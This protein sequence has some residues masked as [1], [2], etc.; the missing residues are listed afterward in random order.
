MFRFKNNEFLAPAFLGG[1]GLL[2]TLH[3]MLT[4]ILKEKVISYSF[5][6]QLIKYFLVLLVFRKLDNS[7]VLWI[8]LFYFTSM[9]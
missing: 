7:I 6:F 5:F 1:K 4:V 2:E 9:F 3:S 8:C